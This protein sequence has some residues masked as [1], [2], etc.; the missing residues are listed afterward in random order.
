MADLRYM[1]KPAVLALVDEKKGQYY[2]TLTSLKR[3]QAAVAVGSETRTVDVTEIAR[4]WSGEYL[5]L[6]REP[7]S[8]GGTLRPGGRGPMVAW[9]EERLAVA[10][11][12]AIPVVPEKTYS[13]AMA[14][15][16]KQFQLVSGN[17]PDGVVGPRTIIGLS[18]FAMSDDPYLYD[19]K[20]GE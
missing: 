13:R 10:Q 18:A 15:E 16:V 5:L 20:G 7:P 2:G 11:G 8:Y 3:D 12:K 9:V 1:N 17:V 6:L 19:K 4:W 14:E